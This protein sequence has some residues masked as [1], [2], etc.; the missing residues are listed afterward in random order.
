MLLAASF[1]GAGRHGFKSARIENAYMPQTDIV[2][3]IEAPAE[4][5]AALRN[6]PLD[7]LELVSNRKISTSDV[8]RLGL[9]EAV[10]V[11]GLAKGL[12]EVLK[13]ALEILKLLKERATEPSKV[14]LRNP[15]GNGVDI[16]SKTDPNRLKKNLEAVFKKTA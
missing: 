11:V 4:I 8:S 15:A 9:A 7:G 13:L 10:V 1:D 2:V 3:Y 12:S 14:R 16:T 6:T 5:S